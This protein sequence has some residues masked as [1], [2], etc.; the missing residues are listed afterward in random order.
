[1]TGK[2]EERLRD[3]T[4]ALA[5]Q[6]GQ[7]DI[8]D[9]HLPGPGHAPAGDTPRWQ[10]AGHRGIARR[11]I[12]AA[13]AAAVVALV[14]TL[15]VIGWTL[16]RPG[17]SNPP[18]RRMP[19]YLI[20]SL[21]GQ[22]YVLSAA[23]GRVVARI[24]PPV[25]GFLI[26]AIAVSS[27]E[28]AF[29][30]AGQV[31]AGRPRVRIEFFKFALGAHGQPGRPQRLGAPVT[32]QVA[33]TVHGPLVVPLAISPDGS[34]LAY[35][36][37]DQ[38]LAAYTPHSPA[39]I[40]IVDLVTGRRRTWS[41]WP[42][43]GTGVSSLSFAEGNR[44]SFVAT[45]GKAVVSA[46][47]VVPAPGSQLDV[48][49]TLNVTAPGSNL[50]ADSRLVTY[51][52]LPYPS[53]I[54]IGPGNGLISR[55]GRTAYLQLFAA[56]GTNRLARISVLTGKVTKI[57]ARFG[58]ASASQ[59]ISIDGNHMLIYLPPR[60]ANSPGNATVCAIL[61]DVY[62]PTGT[63]TRLPAPASCPALTPTGPFDAAW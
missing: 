37:P 60:H 39:T 46:R 15:S 40:T 29:Y 22:G 19:A 6:I 51:A 21:D 28:R 8:P 35:A 1:M 12:P 32:E 44:L 45:I 5:Q 13:A 7:H 33:K 63:I 3:A 24:L 62:L 2:I 27:G 54:T 18:D 10:A 23:S 50:A 25:R 9:L 57:L 36:W 59:A 20:T 30:L 48:F 53:S 4:H 41:L 52:T 61:A 56:N 11:L 58:A 16:R 38:L 47:T 49:M 42:S 17:P 26:D 34:E 31:P 43:A 55:D 14:I